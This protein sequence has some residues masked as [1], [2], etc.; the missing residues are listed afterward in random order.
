MKKLIFLLVGFPIF[1]SW[2][3]D[4]SF[5]PESPHISGNIQ[6]YWEDIKPVSPQIQ[7]QTEKT[8]IYSWTLQK[9]QGIRITTI[10]TTKEWS[11]YLYTVSVNEQPDVDG[12][13]YSRTPSYSVDFFSLTS[14]EEVERSL[15]ENLGEVNSAE[16]PFSLEIAGGQVM[17]KYDFLLNCYAQ[18]LQESMRK[19]LDGRQAFLLPPWTGEYLKKVTYPSDTE[20]T[21][22]YINLFTGEK[23]W[24]NHR[25]AFPSESYYSP[26][27][28]MSSSPRMPAH[29]GSEDCQIHLGAPTSF[30][31]LP[32]KFWGD[33]AKGVIAI[34]MEKSEHSKC[35][36]ILQHQRVW[37]AYTDDTFCYFW[38]DKD[39][40]LRAIK[41]WGDIN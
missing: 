18:N 31:Y 14:P 22:P 2:C 1:F 38:V 9:Q 11:G 23:I 26:S 37:E 12:V 6:Y 19:K 39:T 30:Q 5:S 21:Y 3:Q 28:W 27:L 17:R 16:A 8:L 40:S 25:S 13:L 10:E 7:I 4:K 41:L 32:F 34:T 15:K 35:R 36:E 29:F 24:F 20:M 33:L